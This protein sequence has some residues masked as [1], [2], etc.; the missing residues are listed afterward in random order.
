MVEN[1]L[2]VTFRQQTSL[3]IVSIHLFPAPIT[4]D[5]LVKRCAMARVIFFAFSDSAHCEAQREHLLA[6]GHEI[7]SYDLMSEPWSVSSLRPY[8]GSK[9]VREWFNQSAQ[10][11]LS[12]EIDLEEITPQA[13]LVAMILDPT[14]INA[15]LMR[16]RHHCEAGFQADA[17]SNPKIYQ[18]YH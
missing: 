2:T 8:F 15:P 11:V 18:E 3:L 4:L 5:A 10:R 7:E 12:G 6:S 16:I 14:L 9:P 13:A 1:L 17:F